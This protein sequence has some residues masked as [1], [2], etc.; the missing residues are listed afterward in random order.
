MLNKAPTMEEMQAQMQ[1]GEIIAQT[2]AR[3]RD[4]ANNKMAILEADLLIERQKT[5]QLT[6]QV[7]E[8]QPKDAEDKKAKKKD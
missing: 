1:R 3:Q 8:L 4:D 2:L 7:A 6:K 5:E